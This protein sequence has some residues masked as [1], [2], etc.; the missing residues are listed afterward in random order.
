MANTNGLE[1]RYDVHR[2]DDTEGKH[3]GCRYFVLD[4]KHD[5]YAVVALRAY[6]ASCENDYPQLAADLRELA[7]P[8]SVA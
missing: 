4:P 6:A 3:D 1:S 2:R 8:W 7:D 5:S